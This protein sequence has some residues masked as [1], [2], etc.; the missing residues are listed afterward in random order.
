METDSTYEQKIIPEGK[1]SIDGFI[2]CFDVSSVQQRSLEQQVDFVTHLL[3]GVVKNKKPVVLVTTKNDEADERYVKEAEKI[4]AKKEYKNNIP[5]VGTSAHENVNIELAF[6]TL[7]HLID[8]TKTKP[9][10]IPF[11]EAVKQ[12]KEILDVATEAYKSLLRLQVTDVK[13]TW[14]SSRRKL[15]KE[16]DFGHYVDLFGTDSA[17]RL[18]RRHIYNLRE[19]QIKRREQGFLKNLPEAL[20]H[21][22]PDLV[23]I[24]DRLDCIYMYMY[25][26]LVE[27]L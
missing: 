15:E 10:V 5:L 23:T 8:K 7:A 6:M 4:V 11:T 9:K 18:F 25:N 19:E 2:C 21:F 14:A 12:R 22:L 3:N 20:N 26:V 24:N 16:S 13:V 27:L 17:K 1:L